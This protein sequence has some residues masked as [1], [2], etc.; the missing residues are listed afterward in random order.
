LFVDLLPSVCLEDML[1]D[2]TGTLWFASFNA[3]VARLATTGQWSALR[4]GAAALPSDLMSALL[5]SRDGALWFGTQ[6]AGLARLDS[7]RL[8]PG[9]SRFT[10]A[11]GLA[12]NSVRSLFED[13]ANDLWVGHDDGLSRR[14]NV[15]WSRLDAAAVGVGPPPGAVDQ[16]VEDTTHTLWLRTRAGLWSLD[17]ARSGVPVRHGVADGRLDDD[18]EELLR[19]ADGSLWVA[20]RHGL[21]RRA[22]AGW[23]NWSV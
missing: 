18:A 11:D 3:G 21:S 1:Q 23:T 16:I 9:W 15:G 22:G 10:T 8:P 20:S 5:E 7:T 2:H 6:D 14:S 17:A 19:G 4:A 12:S 13:A